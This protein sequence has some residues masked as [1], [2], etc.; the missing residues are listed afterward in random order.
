MDRPI[1]EYAPYVYD[2]I[3]AVRVGDK[4]C[5]VPAAKVKYFNEVVESKAHELDYPP[6]CVLTREEEN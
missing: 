6:F 4:D 2:T 5:L 3:Y 1:T